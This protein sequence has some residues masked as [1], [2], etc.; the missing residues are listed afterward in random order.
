[1]LDLEVV[2]VR[3]GLLDL[4]TQRD[5][6]LEERHRGGGEGDPAHAE[7]DEG[8]RD[9]HGHLHASEE[10]RGDALAGERVEASASDDGERGTLRT[11]FLVPRGTPLG[12]LHVEGF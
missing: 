7:G 3:L 5:V 11:R 10:L 12:G 6:A 1:M 2:V 4:G 8:H 9:R